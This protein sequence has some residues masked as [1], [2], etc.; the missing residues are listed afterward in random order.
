MTT[1]LVTGATGNVGAYVVDELR[2]YDVRVRAFVRDSGRARGKLGGDVDLAIGDFADAASVRRALAG[3]DRLFLASPNSPAQVEHETRVIDAAVASGVRR[4][5]KLTTPTA[6]VGAPVAFWDWQGR[7]EEHLRRTPMPSVLVQSSFFMTNLLAAAPGI[8]RDAALVA[9]AGG[10]KIAMTDPRDVAAVAAVA[11][12]DASFPARV[13]VTGPEAITYERV[14]RALSE[15]TGR[16][17]PFVDVPD[18]AA[19]EGMGAAGLPDWLADPLVALFAMLRRGA[20]EQVSDMVRAVTGRA[21]RTIEEFLRDRASYFA[22]A[23]VVTPV[24]M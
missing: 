16:Q 22:P 12:T 14:S 17:I 24:R 21:P 7:I 20:D 3:V 6:R 5:V 19:R 23:A 1:I 9:P 18:A 13:R 10:A 15:I 11:L 2:R 8:A 4:I